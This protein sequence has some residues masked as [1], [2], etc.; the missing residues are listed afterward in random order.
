[1]GNCGRWINNSC[2]VPVPA[3][4]GW[5]LCSLWG[6]FAAKVLV[7]WIYLWYEFVPNQVLFLNSLYET[8]SNKGFFQ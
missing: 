8:L 7:L 5:L 1:M 3:G 2:V 6:V 4:D